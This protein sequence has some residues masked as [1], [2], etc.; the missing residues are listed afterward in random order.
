MYKVFVNDVAILLSTEK[1][2]DERYV[3]IPIKKAKVKKLIKKI[4]KGELLYLNLYHEKKEK[5]LKHLQKKISFVK[6]AGGLVYN[7]KKEVLFIFR[8]G[9]WDL[10]KGKTEK[11]EDIETTAIREVEE[12]TGIKNLEITR[13]IDKT[14]H[15]FKRRG[16]YKLK[17]TYWYEMKSDFRGEFIPEVKEGI[18]KVE[19]KDLKEAQ[20]AL[21]KSYENI[22]MIFPAEYLSESKNRISHMR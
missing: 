3:S 6:A 22:K 13:F 5:L 17:V 16:R 15:V 12:E 14:Y 10:P 4:N 1:D 9:K 20:K 19:W 21:N 7:D 18:T 8:N 2:L 11:G